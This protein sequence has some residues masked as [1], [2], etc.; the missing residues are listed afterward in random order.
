LSAAGHQ[1]TLVVDFEAPRN[2]DFVDTSVDPVTL[3]KWRHPWLPITLPT[4]T[5]APHQLKAS[6]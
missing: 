6:R 2:I 3:G 5:G 4:T 1:V